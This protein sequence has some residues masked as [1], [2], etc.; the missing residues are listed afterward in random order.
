MKEF[1]RRIEHGNSVLIPYSL[2]IL[3]G[4]IIYDLFFHIDHPVAN[5]VVAILD[6]VVITIFVIDLIFLA[7]K[8]RNA[9][10]FF[11]RYWLD[12]IAVFP[13]YFFFRIFGFFFRTALTAE[14]IFLG[15]KILHEGVEAEKEVAAVIK[16]ERGV[17][18]LRSGVR[19][20]RILSKTHF[21]SNGE[22][23]LLK[24]KQKPKTDQTEYVQKKR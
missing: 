16:T 2:I 1:W 8:T 7:L 6:G 14:E 18:V 13:F 3:A 19:S 17:K 5:L 24:M 21:F 20:I 10:I 22:N 23:P 15:Q 9:K 4:I 11:K 12:I